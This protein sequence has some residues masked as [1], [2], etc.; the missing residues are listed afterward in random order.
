MNFVIF[1]IGYADIRI[2]SQRRQYSSISQRQSK[3]LSLQENVSKTSAVSSNRRAMEGRISG[4]N[5]NGGDKKPGTTASTLDRTKLTPPSSRKKKRSLK[6]SSRGKKRG[7]KG[8]SQNTEEQKQMLIKKFLESEIAVDENAF[9]SHKVTPPFKPSR[10]TSDTSP[11]KYTEKGLVKKR[12]VSAFSSG[13][14]PPSVQPSIILTREKDSRSD[15]SL[16]NEVIE[17]TVHY[18]NTPSTSKEELRPY[19]APARDIRSLEDS[20]YARYLL[21]K[22]RTRSLRFKPQ[23]EKIRAVSQ[24]AYERSVFQRPH[25][26]FRTDSSEHQ[27]VVPRPRVMSEC[28]H[29]LPHLISAEI[30]DPSSIGKIFPECCISDNHK[31][32]STDNKSMAVSFKSEHDF[33]QEDIRNRKGAGPCAAPS[34]DWCHAEH[35]SRTTSSFPA[36]STSSTGKTTT[37]TKLTGSMPFGSVYASSQDDLSTDLKSRKLINYESSTHL[38]GVKEAWSMPAI[39]SQVMST[40][41]EI[42]SETCQEEATSLSA[43]SSGDD[44]GFVKSGEEGHLESSKETEDLGCHRRTPPRSASRS[45]RKARPAEESRSFSNQREY[46]PQVVGTKNNTASANSDTA[47]A[48]KDSMGNTARGLRDITESGGLTFTGTF[49]GTATLPGYRNPTEVFGYDFHVLPST[50][51]SSPS[52]S[53]SSSKSTFDYKDDGKLPGGMSYKEMSSLNKKGRASSLEVEDL[54]LPAV[55][56]TRPKTAF[57]SSRSVS[58]KQVAFEVSENDDPTSSRGILGKHNTAHV[59][60][61]VKGSHSSSHR[62]V[63]SPLSSSRHSA[64]ASHDPVAAPNLTAQQ[65]NQTSSQASYPQLDSSSKE[66][67]SSCHHHSHCSVSHVP[68]DTMSAL[69]GEEYVTYRPA[70]FRGNAD[71]LSMPS[72]VYIDHYSQLQVWKQERMIRDVHREITRR[73][74]KHVQ[75]VHPSREFMIS[76]FNKSASKNWTLP[77][78]FHEVE[79]YWIKPILNWHR[80][81]Y[82]YSLV[83]PKH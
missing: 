9:T 82:I 3:N 76:I 16:Y 78:V 74:G 60:D 37:L 5:H 33:H 32:E 12:P 55:R 29:M 69:T 59:G 79:E 73:Y 46:F 39:S 56:A 2:M 24:S 70:Y 14:R 41:E 31:Q 34:K 72:R 71:A 21:D 4:N 58:T 15:S 30:Q 61:R 67:S 44:Y 20:G 25:E 6:G 83:Y 48:S 65:I 81:L 36:I 75:F 57:G 43:A 66:F 51:A 17:E 63:L 52:P 19:S 80:R 10:A 54:E 35:Q 38:Y 49:D 68:S 23:M 28:C 50:S 40:D 7:A 8:D 45:P 62:S 18:F 13:H 11:V 64:L 26:C 42:P 77:E 27:C 22:I 53:S 47:S 1:F